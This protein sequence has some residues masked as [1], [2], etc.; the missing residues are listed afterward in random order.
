MLAL[1]YLL[2][3]GVWAVGSLY[4]PAS[5]LAAVICMFGLEQWGQTAGSPFAANQVFTNIAVGVMVVAALAT[6]IVRGHRV[7]SGLPATYWL[8]VALFTYAA[9]SLL[10]TPNPASALANWNRAYPYVLTV[11]FMTPLLCTQPRDFVVGL[12]WLVILGGAISFAVLFF[13]RWGH[14]GL[15]VDEVLFDVETNPLAVASMAGQVL[16]TAVLVPLSKGKLWRWSTALL[17]APICIAVVART[18]SRGQLLAVLLGLAV[19]WPLA[20]SGVIA[21]RLLLAPA[22]IALIGLIA[23]ASLDYFGADTARW[24]NAGLATSDVEGRMQMA[25]L[26][27]SKATASVHGLLFGLG[28]SASYDLLGIYPHVVAL[29]I[30]GEEGLIGLALF[31]LALWFCGLAAVRARTITLDANVRSALAAL[32]GATVFHLVV[33]F[34][35]GSMLLNPLL[36]LHAI[37]VPKLLLSALGAPSSESVEPQQR[38]APFANLMNA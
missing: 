16:I 1:S 8:V 5:A 22:L 13:G 30:L 36:F 29:E 28:S 32:I 10:W 23:F 20:R 21:I 11:V 9:V 15:I 26:L 35:Q 25:G 38:P 18:G 2:L 33:S 7:F 34:K 19:A 27:L 37:L 24:N 4:A 6:R 14:R 12:R 3:L 17:L 31:T